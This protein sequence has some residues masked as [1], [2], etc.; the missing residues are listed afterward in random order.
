MSLQKI[1]Q[2]KQTLV[3][4]V[5]HCLRIFHCLTVELYALFFFFTIAL[6][7]WHIAVFL[8][9]FNDVINYNFIHSY[10]KVAYYYHVCIYAS[11]K[12]FSEGKQAHVGMEA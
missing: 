5:N 4:F 1:L 7:E 9:S 12:K 11:H 8:P 10:C 3:D 6:T 2:W